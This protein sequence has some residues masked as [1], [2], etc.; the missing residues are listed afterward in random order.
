MLAQPTTDRI[1]FDQRT[2]SRALPNKTSDEISMQAESQP[3]VEKDPAVRD[4]GRE[5]PTVLSSEACLTISLPMA[6]GTGSSSRVVSAQMYIRLAFAPAQVEFGFDDQ[7]PNKKMLVG[8]VPNCIVPH[9]R[10]E[11]AHSF[12][13]NPARSHLSPGS[14][15]WVMRSQGTKPNDHS[16]IRPTLSDGKRLVDICFTEFSRLTEMTVSA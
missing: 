14:A 3:A 11:P 15:D 4:Q 7:L 8:T 13:R 9:H 10:I 5:I 6:R 1:S 12:A 16:L 2:W